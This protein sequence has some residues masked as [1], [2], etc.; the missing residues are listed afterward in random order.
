[1]D[2]SIVPPVDSRDEP[3]QAL[4]AG[5]RMFYNWT[6]ATERGSGRVWPCRLGLARNWLSVGGKMRNTDVGQ[7]RRV[8]D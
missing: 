5:I 1:M 2:R 6:P 3:G 7:A 8:T 4:V